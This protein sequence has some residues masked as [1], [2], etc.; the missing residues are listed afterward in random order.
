MSVLSQ[1][2]G[3]SP[4]LSLLEPEALKGRLRDLIRAYVRARSAGLAQ[5]VV[6]HIEALYRHPEL[7]DPALFCA[8]RRLAIHWRWLAAQQGDVG[9]A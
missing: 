7:R 1:P 6:S 9:S 4:D 2:P 8:Y 3:H 5:S